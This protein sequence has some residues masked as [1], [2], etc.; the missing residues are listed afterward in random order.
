MENF[1]LVLGYPECKNAKPFVET[2][3]V[4]C[5]VCGGKVQIRKSKSGR[6]FYICENNK[7]VDQGCTYISWNKPKLGEKFDPEAQK[8]AYEAWK[9]KNAKKTA[10]KKGTKKAVAKSKSKNSTSKATKTTVKK[11]S[12]KKTTKSKAKK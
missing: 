6:T 1:Q 8:A 12:S 2:I 4:P 3:D 11:T 5:P 7:G 10:N 9:E